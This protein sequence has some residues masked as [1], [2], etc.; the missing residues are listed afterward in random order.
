MMAT[1]FSGTLVGVLLLLAAATLVWRRLGLLVRG[2]RQPAEPGSALCLVRGLQGIIIALALLTL[3]SG[4]LFEQGWLLVFGA[5][6]LVEELYETGLLILILRTSGDAD[7]GRRRV[8][9]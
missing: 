3:A 4:V 6:F 8:S 1:R 9:G 2:F 5:V 7:A